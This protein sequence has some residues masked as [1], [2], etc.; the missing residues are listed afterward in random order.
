[1]LHAGDVYNALPPGQWPRPLQPAP[2]GHN[3]G[4]PGT[5]VAGQ[6]GFSPPHTAAMGIGLDHFA[7]PREYQRCARGLCQ[8]S[9]VV[10]NLCSG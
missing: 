4:S 2:V 5:D 10:G 6:S 7:L 1:M 3:R 9:L 8:F